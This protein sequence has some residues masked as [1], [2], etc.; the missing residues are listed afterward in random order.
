MADHPSV[1]VVMS[2]YNAEKYLRPAIESILAQTFTDFE[3][4]IIDDGSTDSTR[5]IIAEYAGR[6][7]RIV[8]IPNGNN[9]GLT[10]SLNK[11]L[12]AARGELIARMDADDISY[13]QRL[14][15]QIEY[16]TGNPDVCLVA[17]SYERIDE[18][19]EIL[20]RESMAPG[21]ERLRAMMRKT[22]SIVHGS[23]MY[24]RKPIL[25]LGKYREYCLHNEDYDLWLRIVDKHDID[26]LPDILYKFR[27][28][29]QSIAFAKRDEMEHYRALV[30]RFA[31]E[32]QLYGKDTYEQAADYPKPGTT[33]FRRRMSKFH[34]RRGVTVMGLNARKR[35]RG[36]LWK[37]I[38]YEPTRLSAWLWLLIT[39][40]P[41][42]AV[43]LGRRIWNSWH[44]RPS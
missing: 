42:P 1:S 28:T 38:T 7:D 40:L 19:G 34:Y 29:S 41:L 15:K 22:C 4:I 18:N 16:M 27:I 10:P 6:D 8:L 17:A 32:R 3:F 36:E 2:A 9:L 25:D 35:A 24:R 33:S 43:E 13:P 12:D 44:R 14:E 30:L 21:K 37:S 11:G 5:G 39:F 31:K 20:S 26:I 23:V